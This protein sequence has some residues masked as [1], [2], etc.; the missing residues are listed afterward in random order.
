V[1]IEFILYYPYRDE[2]LPMFERTAREA[3]PEP[4]KIHKITDIG[5]PRMASLS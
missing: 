5:Q 1:G 3:I 4:R 2:Q